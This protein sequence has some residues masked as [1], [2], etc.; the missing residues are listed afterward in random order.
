MFCNQLLV[1]PA[2]ITLSYADYK[3]FGD[4]QF[5]ASRETSPI[6]LFSNGFMPTWCRSQNICAGK[7][8]SKSVLTARSVTGNDAIG[9]S[10]TRFA[11]AQPLFRK[12]HLY[13]WPNSLISLRLQWLPGANGAAASRAEQHHGSR[14]SK[15]LLIARNMARTIRVVA[16]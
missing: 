14:I 10:F 8:F 9:V 11:K 16:A 15:P 4:Q 5:R 13:G 2:A 1:A 3:P 12:S 7:R 6:D